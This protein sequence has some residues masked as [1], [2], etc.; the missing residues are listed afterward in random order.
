MNS[1]TAGMANRS[2]ARSENKSS[3]LL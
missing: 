3:L 1:A 2:V